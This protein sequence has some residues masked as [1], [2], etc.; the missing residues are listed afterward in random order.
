[1]RAISIC[2][3]VMFCAQAFAVFA[4]EGAEAQKRTKHIGKEPIFG[5]AQAV[6]VDDVALFH[7]SQF[8][9]IDFD[10]KLVGENATEQASMVLK[11]IGSLTNALDN[12][13][14]SR[15]VKLN[16]YVPSEAVANELRPFLRTQFRKK[17]LPAI[18][19]V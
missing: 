2:A 16:V 4:D 18:S 5:G 10:G 6:V 17:E 13:P 15:L 3:A 1:M 14:E 8:L 11:N 7:T 12:R 19:L 9:P